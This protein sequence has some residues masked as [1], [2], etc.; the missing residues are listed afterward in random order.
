MIQQVWLLQ[1]TMWEDRNQVLHSNRAGLY[2]DKVRVIDHMIREE[3]IIRNFDIPED[4]YELFRGNMNRLLGGSNI[5]N[6]M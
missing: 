1:F 5:Y 3:L 6:K 2:K 4:S